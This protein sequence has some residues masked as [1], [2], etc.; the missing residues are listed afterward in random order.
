MF[1]YR[2]F[3]FR[4][5]LLLP[6][7]KFR[8]PIARAFVFLLHFVRPFPDRIYLAA[9]SVDLF[10]SSG[11]FSTYCRKDPSP[12]IESVLFFL[13][14]NIDYIFFSRHEMTCFSFNDLIGFMHGD[15]HALITILSVNEKY[16]ILPVK[17]QPMPTQCQPQP[18]PHPTP[19]QTQIKTPKTNPIHAP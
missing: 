1:D 19:K 4:F 15:P 13:F 16:L 18:T 10:R 17:P 14:C 7:Q 9:F 8:T 12:M 6:L 2:L 3:R 11:W 5:D